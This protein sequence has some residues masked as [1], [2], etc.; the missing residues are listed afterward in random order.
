MNGGKELPSFTEN[1]AVG[2]RSHSPHLAII[3]KA[4][5]EDGKDE[6]GRCSDL[7]GSALCAEGSV[8]NLGFCS[9]ISHNLQALLVA[10]RGGSDAA[11]VGD[12]VLR[13][14]NKRRPK[15]STH[16]A[17][18]GVASSNPRTSNMRV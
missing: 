5:P 7:T 16:A 15:I 13:R 2:S 8:L 14:E 17:N 11:A 3:L 10:P 18:V 9:E 1:G 4:D 6:P 12:V